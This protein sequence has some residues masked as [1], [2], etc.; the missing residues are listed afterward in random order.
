MGFAD[1]GDSVFPISVNQ[2]VGPESVVAKK[3]ERCS[4][5]MLTSTDSLVAHWDIGQVV[6]EAGDANENEGRLVEFEIDALKGGIFVSEKIE[7]EEIE[8]AIE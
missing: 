6:T 8:V 4:L 7:S 1:A 3:D 5:V 2:L